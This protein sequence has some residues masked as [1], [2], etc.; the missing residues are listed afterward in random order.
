MQNLEAKF[1][2]A[3]LKQ[4]RTRAEAIGF[5]FSAT[6]IQRDTFFAVANGKLKLREENRGASLIHYQRDTARGFELSNYTIAK[7]TDA[8]NTRAIL[9]S[10]LGV[11]A[12]VRK[13]RTLLL[14]ENIRLH[15]DEVEGIGEFGEI[16]AVLQRN[17]SLD[18]GHT[19]LGEILRALEVRTRDR[20]EVSYFE[21]MSRKPAHRPAP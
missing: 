19:A 3:G 7:I 8:A 18:A 2:L 16:E 17:G 5:V 14:R 20:I 15:L 13:R 12:K 1:R 4:A 9:A 11:I 6:L 10:A 21:L